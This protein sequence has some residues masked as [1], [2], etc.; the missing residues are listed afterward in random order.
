MKEKTVKE[1][2]L[3]QELLIKVVKFA[4]P[5]KFDYIYFVTRT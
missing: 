3:A 4:I 5:G 1:G 2:T